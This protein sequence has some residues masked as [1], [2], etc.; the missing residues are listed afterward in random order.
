[1]AHTDLTGPI[2]QVSSERFRNAISYMDDYS[3][4]AFAYLLKQRS[5]TTRA[6]K[7]FLADSSHMTVLNV[8]D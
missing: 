2:V 5:D 3:G 8:P 6:T 1:M 7:K 4:I